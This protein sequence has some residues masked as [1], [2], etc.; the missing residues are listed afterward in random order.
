MTHIAGCGPSA[1]QLL[2]TNDVNSATWPD[3]PVELEGSS[4]GEAK[5]SVIQ[6]NCNDLG[7]LLK[8]SGD[9]ESEIVGV[10]DMLNTTQSNLLTLMKHISKVSK[11]GAKK[12][13]SMVKDRRKN[14]K[15]PIQLSSVCEEE[16]V[17]VVEVFLNTK[18]ERDTL[19]SNV[20]K[21]EGR[22]KALDQ[23]KGATTSQL[24][25]KIQKLTDDLADEKA[26]A[27]DAEERNTAATAQIVS[28]AAAVEAVNA[29]VATANTAL[30]SARE[31]A[32]KLEETNK[33]L[34][35]KGLEMAGS[36][37]AFGFGGFG[38]F[39]GSDTSGDAGAAAAG[40]FVANNV[41]SKDLTSEYDAT[42][43]ALR[44]CAMGSSALTEYDAGTSNYDPADLTA[45]L[46]ENLES[47]MRFLKG[48]FLL[49]DAKEVVKLG[50]ALQLVTAKVRGNDRQ[51]VVDAFQ[52]QLTSIRSCAQKLAF[53]PTSPMQFEARQRWPIS[54][55]HVEQL[56][57]V[58]GK[59]LLKSVRLVAGLFDNLG[60]KAVGDFMYDGGVVKNLEFIIRLAV[61]AVELNKAK[62]RE[63]DYTRV[64]GV[65]TTAEAEELRVKFEAMGEASGETDLSKKTFK[66]LIAL[67]CRDNGD[68]VPK[69][70]DLDAVFELADD[71]RSGTVDSEEFLKLY[72]AVKKG[73]VKGL[74]Q[75]LVEQQAAEAGAEE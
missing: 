19:S 49:L 20:G 14:P 37:T 21:L 46:Q 9:V 29:E 34:L 36:G 18:A 30:A 8:A 73:E 1:L 52:K 54:E 72:A 66:K 47:T 61:K 44:R 15:Y 65:L 4:V 59:E 26:K 63:T 22:L 41:S 10:K 17:K 35:R 32:A 6:L 71:D 67:V 55:A 60:E 31:T 42:A 40:A 75:K 12:V 74:G 69:D 11:T 25:D 27:K 16:V 45:V 5:I 62:G 48:E 23:E 38:S 57:L 24:S 50:D 58:E 13:E 64:F 68:K 7:E 28:L 3:L 43:L 70:K 33:F 56:S 39:F 51:P 53:G 2:R